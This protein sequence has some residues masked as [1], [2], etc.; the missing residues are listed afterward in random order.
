[1]AQIQNPTPEWR[2]PT[3]SVVKGDFSHLSAAKEHASRL[4]AYLLA[5][6]IAPQSIPI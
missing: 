1:M 5:L 4:A 3:T 6:E 2:S